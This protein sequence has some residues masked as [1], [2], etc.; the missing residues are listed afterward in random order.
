MKKHPFCNAKAVAAAVYL[1]LLTAFTACKSE[2]SLSTVVSE[3]NKQL[4]FSSQ[5]LEL[6]DIAVE[7]TIVVFNSI[8]DES[9]VTVPEFQGAED[10]MKFSLFSILQEAGMGSLIDYCVRNHTPI[11]ISMIGNKT[12]AE[13]RAV[14]SIEQLNQLVKKTSSQNA[15]EEQVQDADSTTQAPADST[16][17]QTE[18]APD[19]KK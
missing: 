15:G 7:D 13:S 10:V 2:N 16:A 12:K 3:F 5:G 19:V 8:F 4:P 17:Q 1:A 14:F 18:T 11:T 6:K 9:D